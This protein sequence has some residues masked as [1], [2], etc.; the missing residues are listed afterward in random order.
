M[1]KEGAGKKILVVDDK[2]DA[3]GLVKEVLGLRGYEVAEAS[4]G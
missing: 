3:R 4:T 1:E 2:E